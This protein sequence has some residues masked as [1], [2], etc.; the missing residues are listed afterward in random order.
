MKIKVI[1]S[2]IA[3]MFPFYFLVMVLDYNYSIILEGRGLTCDDSTLKENLPVLLAERSVFSF[4]I[5]ENTTIR[6]KYQ[7]NLDSWNIVAKSLGTVSV[8]VNKFNNTF[9]ISSKINDQISIYNKKA[10]ISYREIRIYD[11]KS[12]SAFCNPLSIIVPIRTGGVYDP[13]SKTA[14]AIFPVPI[15]IADCNNSNVQFSVSGNYINGEHTIIGVN[16]NHAYEKYILNLK[17]KV[18]KLEN[19]SSPIKV[20]ILNPYRENFGSPELL[21]SSFLVFRN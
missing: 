14:S 17:K 20:T 15:T 2:L 12:D 8:D 18:V 10:Q 16:Y 6:F 3:T 4:S 13:Y 5:C 7:G 9:Q 11:I 19:V 1:S 21:I